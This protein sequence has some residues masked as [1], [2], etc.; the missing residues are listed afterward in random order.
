[1]TVADKGRMDTLIRL[2]E[3]WHISSTFSD[4]TATVQENVDAA[5][6][7][8]LKRICLVERVR[9]TS[10]WVGEFVATC[11]A[12]ARSALVEVSSGVEVEILDTRGGL[13]LP[14][15]AEQADSLYVA[16]RRLPTPTGPMELHEARRQIAS[17]QL[18]PAR[19]IEWLVRASANATKDR[20]GVVLAHPFSILPE[21]GID[22]R[23]VHPAYVR[24]LAGALDEQAAHVEVSE[25][26]RSP[27]PEVVGCFLTAGVNVRA[28]TGSCSPNTVGR[29]SWC[30][31]VVAGNANRTPRE[32]QPELA[33]AF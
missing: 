20:G 1:M 11:R 29:Y 5:E 23:S 13:D 4:G 17:G 30:R 31:E 3:D 28:A 33:Y 2:D 7:C 14:R 8:G 25:R 10:G 9:R 21:L 27:S 24:W 18:L 32:R 12:A 26:W 22:I 19:A 15:S 16:A 6:R